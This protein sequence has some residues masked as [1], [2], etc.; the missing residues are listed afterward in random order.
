MVWDAV[1]LKAIEDARAVCNK[2]GITFYT[3]NYK[4]E[5]QEKVIKYFCSEYEEW[6]N[7]QSLCYL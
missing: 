1:V 3:L 2:L 4:A 5:F 7:S 6:Q